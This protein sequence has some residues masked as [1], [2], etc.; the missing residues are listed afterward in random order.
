MAFSH[1]PVTG[2]PARRVKVTRKV[3]LAPWLP[4]AAQKRLGR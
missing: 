1:G 4:Q 3:T 2:Q